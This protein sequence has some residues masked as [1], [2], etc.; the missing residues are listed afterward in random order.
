MLLPLLCSTQ[1]APLKILP[2]TT[3]CYH[4]HHPPPQTLPKPSPVYQYGRMIHK[5]QRPKQS[6]NPS[7]L[8]H[9]ISHYQTKHT[10]TLHRIPPSAAPLNSLSIANQTFPDHFCGEA[11]V[12]QQ[13]PVSVGKPR[14]LFCADQPLAYRRSSFLVGTTLSGFRTHS[15]CLCLV[16]Y[17]WKSTSRFTTRRVQ[18]SSR[19]SKG[20]VEKIRN[21]SRGLFL[22]LPGTFLLRGGTGIRHVLVCHVYYRFETLWRQIHGIVGSTSRQ[23]AIGYQF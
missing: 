13:Q 19:V 1:Q 6:S 21:N 8:P 16:F 11:K 22:V 3:T 12:V 9:Q 10:W 14:Y 4:N 17:V 20:P 23:S 18:L 7:Q 2:T 5:K 15:F